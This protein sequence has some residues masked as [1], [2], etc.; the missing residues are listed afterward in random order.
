M[1]AFAVRKSPVN[2]TF[3]VVLALLQKSVTLYSLKKANIFVLGLSFLAVNLIDALRMNGKTALVELPV[4]LASVITTPPCTA[5][6]AS[7]FDG[8]YQ[9]CFQDPHTEP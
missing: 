8:V 2:V 9:N 6:A 5:L 1:S 7:L 3:E 4:V